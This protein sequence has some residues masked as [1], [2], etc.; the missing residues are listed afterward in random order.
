MD[1]ESEAQKSLQD[2]LSGDRKAQARLASLL[3]DDLRQM[4]TAR[5]RSEGA[6]HTLQPT[7]LVHEAF[8]RLISQDR[9]DWQGRTHFLAVAATT[10]R[11]V[12][13]DHARSRG[14]KKRG[15]AQRRRELDPD[16][17]ADWQDPTELIALDEALEELAK[18]QPRQ[19]RVIELRF[20]G[21]LSLEETAEILEVSRDTIKLD[22]RFARAWLNR[23]LGD[24]DTDR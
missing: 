8:L 21:G 11:R 7:A 14:A 15:G 1:R 3:Y 20:F 2:S 10:M 9:V 5:M 19:A 13:V 12:L 24:R 22:W 18:K 16:Q 6:H 23:S 4:A 17:P